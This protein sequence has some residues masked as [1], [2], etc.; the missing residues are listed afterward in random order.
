MSIVKGAFGYNARDFQQD[1]PDWC[2]A[3]KSEPVHNISA[4]GPTNQKDS[5][6]ASDFL[7]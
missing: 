7:T 1:R 4:R 6:A 3:S 2:N 5:T